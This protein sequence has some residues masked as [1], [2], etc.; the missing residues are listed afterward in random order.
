MSGHKL[1]EVCNLFVMEVVGRA[2][3]DLKLNWLGL[4]FAE[5]LE[6][7]GP[8]RRPGPVSWQVEL[9]PPYVVA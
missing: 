5:T 3:N 8:L 7:V 1:G 4:Q 9:T 2:A 6:A